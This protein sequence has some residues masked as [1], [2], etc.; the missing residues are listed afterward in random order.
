M[1]RRRSKPIKVWRCGNFVI[2]RHEAPTLGEDEWRLSDYRIRGL[3][4]DGRIGA[5]EVIEVMSL[6][7]AWCVRVMPGSQ[8]ETIMSAILDESEDVIDNEW[9]RL[10]CTNLMTAS[11]IPNGH[12]HS[13]LML[14]TAAY[15]DPSLISGNPLGRKRRAFARDVKRVRDAFLA[16]RRDYDEFVGTLPDDDTRQEAL[17]AEAEA[18]LSEGQPPQE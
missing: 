14:L 6:D 11:S 15:S 17:R 1:G 4:H 5:V 2:R 13:A 9:L 12:Y 7:G 3:V 10:V 16:W 18:V 8:M